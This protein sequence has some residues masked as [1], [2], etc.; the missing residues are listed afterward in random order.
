MIGS[1]KRPAG[2]RGAANS[3]RHDFT[4]DS[5]TLRQWGIVLRHHIAGDFKATLDDFWYRRQSSP[6]SAVNNFIQ[7]PLLKPSR[8]LRERRISRRNGIFAKK[9][10]YCMADGAAAGCHRNLHRRR[11]ILNGQ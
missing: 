7:P 4:H 8:N 6:A 1:L 2:T 5:T 3:H 9:S 10:S 11:H